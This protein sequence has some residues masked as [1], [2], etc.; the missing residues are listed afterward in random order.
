MAY[1]EILEEASAA[2]RERYGEDTEILT[3]PVTPVIA[4]HT[5]PGA[6]GLAWMAE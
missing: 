2:L 3:G 5:G 4:T 6:W 1:P